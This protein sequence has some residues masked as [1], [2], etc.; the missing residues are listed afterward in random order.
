MRD[1]IKTKGLSKKSINL[2]LSHLGQSK[3]SEIQYLKFIDYARND[4]ENFFLDSLFFI[5]IKR[6]LFFYY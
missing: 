4:R 1:G 3:C 2:K 6:D 5:K